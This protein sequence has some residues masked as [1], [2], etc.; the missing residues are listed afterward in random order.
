M[1]TKTTD[2]KTLNLIKEISKRKAEIAKIEKPSWKTNCSFSYTEDGQNSLNLQVE[3][4]I[5]NLVLIAAFLGEKSRSYAQT[6]EY[7]N[8]SDIPEFTWKG[9]SLSDWLSDIKSRINK[10]QISSKKKQ[11]EVLE[12]RATA[13]ISPELRAELELQAIMNELGE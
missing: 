1:T 8:L 10:I 5:R 4:S 6:I 11:L 2:E 12:N 7:L 13:L 9:Y 3:S